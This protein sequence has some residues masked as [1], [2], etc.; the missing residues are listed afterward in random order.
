M[1]SSLT[2]EHAEVLNLTDKQLEAQWPLESLAEREGVQVAVNV[3]QPAIINFIR[4]QQ[5]AVEVQ[6]PAT[7]TQPRRSA[8]PKRST[9]PAPASSGVDAKSDSD[10]E[11]S[12]SSEHPPPPKFTERR[13][14]ICGKNIK[15]VCKAS[16]RN[17]MNSSQACKSLR[18]LYLSFSISALSPLARALSPYVYVRRFPFQFYHSLTHP[19]LLGATRRS[20]TPVEKTA[21]IPHPLRLCLCR[22]RSTSQRS[23]KR[24]SATLVAKSV[25]LCRTSGPVRRLP[26]FVSKCV[27]KCSC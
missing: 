12:D 2:G 7:P 20:R 11:A 3:S 22:P 14:T 25:R 24:P 19:Q 16:L 26:S 23:S 27:S 13:C 17:H 10:H 6:T 4:Q 9:P 8:R 21:S 18:S 5:A 1:L 15:M